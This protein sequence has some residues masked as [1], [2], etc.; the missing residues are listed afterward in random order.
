MRPDEPT[1]LTAILV[2]AQY[3]TAIRAGPTFR[4]V[5]SRRFDD[6]GVFPPDQPPP[7]SALPL[8]EIERVLA[9][10]RSPELN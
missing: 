4:V 1:L 3:V 10:L 8:A 5:R 2:P 6:L 9:E 7:A